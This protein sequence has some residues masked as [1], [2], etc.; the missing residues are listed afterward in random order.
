[1]KKYV[2]VQCC[3]TKRKEPRKFKA[4]DLYIS[5]LFN[6]SMAYAK[7]LSPDKIFI[8]SAKYGLLE[9]EDVIEDYNE[10]LNTKS[11]P[12]IKEWSV[13]VLTSLSQKTDLQTD[14][15]IFLAG[16]KYR[17]Y[18]IENIRN[19]CIPL[20]GLRIGKQLAFYKENT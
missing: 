3:K 12:E 8:L 10:T 1:M 19:V 16:E 18:L 14:K 4:C 17:K 11:A 6:K 15:F 13:K 7:S 20:K 2:L 5:D 9:E